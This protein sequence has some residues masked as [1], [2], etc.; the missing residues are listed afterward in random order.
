MSEARAQAQTTVDADLLPLATGMLFF[1]PIVFV[2]NELGVLLRF[3]ELGSAVLYPPYAALTAALVASPR[4][5]WTWYVLAA[6]MVHAVANLPHWTLSWVLLADLANITRALVAAAGLRLFFGGPPKLDSIPELVL[7][8]VAAVIV[9]PAVG[10]TIGAA[11]LVVHATSAT[12]WRPW[13]GW[14]MASALTALT[15]LPM[16]LS[17]IRTGSAWHDRVIDRRRVAEGLALA[18]A[19]AVTCTI[20]FLLRITSRWDLALLVYGPLPL[21]FWAALRFGPGGASV[22]L[23]AV[24]VAAIWGADR[25]TGPFLSLSADDSVLTLQLVLLLTALPVLCIAAVGGARHGVV[26]LY[27]ALLASLQDHVAI[28][29]ARGMVLE[30]N[31]S[32]RRFADA[33]HP[34]PF[35]RVR[36]GDDYLIA[37]REAVSILKKM[38]KAESDIT[39]ARA[40]AGVQSVLRGEQRR[41]EMEYEQD[42]EARQEWYTMRVEALERPDGGAVVTRANV[43]AR[44]RAQLE[45]EEQR[46]EL[47]HLARVGV[48]GQLS[49]ALAHELSQPLSSILS[50][51]EAARHL[52]RNERVDYTELGEILQD[53]VTEDRRASQVISGLRAMLKRGE[54]RVQPVDTVELVRETLELAHAELITRGVGATSYV[55]PSLPPVLADRVQVQQVLLNLILN[56]CEAMGDTLSDDRRLHF[57]ATTTETGDVRFSIRDGGNGFPPELIDRLF[58]PFVTTKSEGLGLGLSIARAIVAAHGGRIWAENNLGRGATVHCVLSATSADAVAE[59]RHQGADPSEPERPWSAIDVMGAGAAPAYS[60]SGARHTS[61]LPRQ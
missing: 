14:F 40:M 51:A 50:N 34:C 17:A 42:G 53:I 58:E 8:C 59:T 11:N 20:A 55:E 13:T 1:I 35:D 52:L 25:G 45:I 3:P 33:G 54:T 16:F 5:H 28:L 39:A 22:A 47:S 24:A 7:F 43:S 23:T 4:R 29:D 49:G 57:S 26:Q 30:V 44:R 38:G 12:Y 48:L 6:T 41:F 21:L 61:P 19:L 60:P 9:A 32:W 31:E 56:A 37:C 10:A 27:H 36:A 18:G 46:R 2:G 15:M